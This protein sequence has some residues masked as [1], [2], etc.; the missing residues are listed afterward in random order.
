MRVRVCARARVCVQPR[1][2][3]YLRVYTC[4]CVCYSVNFQPQHTTHAFATYCYNYSLRQQIVGAT[5][6]LPYLLRGCDYSIDAYIANVAIIQCTSQMNRHSQSARACVYISMCVCVYTCEYVC[7]H[8]NTNACIH[9]YT[10]AHTTSPH[11]PPGSP[12]AA[13]WCWA[14]V[15]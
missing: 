8:A 4:D 1:V 13:A 6:W 12:A 7:I 2:R 5:L 11:H 15:S 3:A 14:P 10:H 9:V